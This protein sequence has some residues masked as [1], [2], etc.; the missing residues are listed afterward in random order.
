MPI[1]RHNAFVKDFRKTRL[2]DG[3]FEKFVNFIALLGDNKP[4]PI[5]AKDHS[6]KGQYLD[7]REFHLGGDV[8]VIYLLA[9]QNI[10]LLR[11]GSHAQLF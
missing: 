10:I 2:T 6:L 1:K 9:K 3:Q 7:C 11:I 8:L 4:L 5:E